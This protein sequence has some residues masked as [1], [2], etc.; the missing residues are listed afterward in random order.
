MLRAV[1]EAL[2]DARRREWAFV[3]AATVRVAGPTAMLA[4]TDVG[5]LQ[6][7]QTV[8]IEGAA[9]GVGSYAVQIAKLLG[10][11]VIGAASTAARVARRRSPP[12]PTT[13]STTRSRAGTTP[14]AS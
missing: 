8:L 12:A 7:G 3:L 14:S 2:A 10:A 11:T 9:G 4:L 1:A 5:G 6:A 13:S